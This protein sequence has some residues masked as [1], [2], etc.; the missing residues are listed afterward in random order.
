MKSNLRCGSVARLVIGLGAMM[1]AVGSAGAQTV[2]VDLGNNS[3]FRG[4]SVTNP[5]VKGHYWNSVWSGAYYPNLVDL[6]GSSTSL[7]LGF[8]AAEGNDSY[9]GP[10]GTTFDPSQ[11]VY[12]SAALGNLGINEA[13]YDYYVN[14]RFQIQGLD[15]SKTYNLTLFGSH[16]YN[17]NNTTRYTIYT[18]STYTTPVAFADLVVGVNDAHNQDT[19]ATINGVS[20]QTGNILYIGFAGAG[21]GSGYL[22]D[23][24]I[25]ASVPEPSALLLLASGIGLAFCF[26]RR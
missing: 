7:A 8:D 19:V 20:P 12:N 1:G 23:L 18:D 5:D 3:S 6:N 16:K 14:S 22:N 15:S 2:L 26:R 17:D 4:A 9:N 11:S 25:T 13:V 24:Q 10:A 21:G